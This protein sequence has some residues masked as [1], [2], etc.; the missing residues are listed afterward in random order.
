MKPDDVVC[1]CFDVPLRKLVNFAKRTRPVRPSQMTGCLGAGTGCGWCIPFL[2][3]VAEDAD[4]TALADMTADS[5]EE[6][7]RSYIKG[8]A[9]NTFDQ[10]APQGTGSD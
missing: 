10:A 5:Y 3:R 1:L 9:K 4:S 6:E 8:D 7:R 2:V